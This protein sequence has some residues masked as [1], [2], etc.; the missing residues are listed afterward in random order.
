MGLFRLLDMVVDFVVVGVEA[1]CLDL[2]NILQAKKVVSGD[3][4]I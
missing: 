1:G 4:N 3:L 2:G